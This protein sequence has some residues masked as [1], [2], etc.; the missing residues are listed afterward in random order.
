MEKMNDESLSAEECK[1]RA[2]QLFQAKH[3]DQAI[4][5]YTRAIELDN[6]V[7]AFYAN[8]AFA[9]LKMECYGLALADA[10]KAI[11]LDP[12]YVKAYYR[13]AMAYMPLG[14]YHKSVQDLR[15]VCQ[16]APNDIDAKRH[17]QECQ[18]IV[19]KIDFEKAIA[20]DDAQYK[21]RG[22]VLQSLNVEDIIVDPTY[23]GPILENGEITMPFVRDMTEA[24][25]MQKSLHKKYVYQV[26]ENSGT[27]SPDIYIYIYTHNF[28]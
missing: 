11:E 3:F 6:S 14:N 16:M 7:A 10:D 21:S 18:K 1:S 22:Q 12:G 8:R 19:K 15:R 24:F 17:L 23:K 27:S 13:R 4:E 28:H 20:F 26:G 25:R 2:N 5:Y 9:Y